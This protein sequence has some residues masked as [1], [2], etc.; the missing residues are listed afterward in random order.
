MRGSTTR[1]LQF[2]NMPWLGNAQ[3]H[4]ILNWAFAPDPPPTL[5]VPDFQLVS[6]L[7]AH[8]V[9]AAAYGNPAPLGTCTLLTT[10]GGHRG[11]HFVFVSGVDLRRRVLTVHNSAVR[12]ETGQGVGSRFRQGLHGIGWQCRWE[13]HG[14]QLDGN[15]CGMR[16]VV[17][18]I[19]ALRLLPLTGR[20][21]YWAVVFCMEALAANGGEGR[22]MAQL[23]QHHLSLVDKRDDPQSHARID[24]LTRVALEEYE[25]GPAGQGARNN[26]RAAW[27]N[28]DARHANNPEH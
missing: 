27:R 22:D 16:A 2:T 14:T 12:P 26:R 8:T 11:L 24:K 1:N 4:V 23:I 20:L 18:A 3:I 25:A 9:A 21:P 19:E 17:F 13:Y 28:P 15:T 7:R 10:D 5:V 6:I